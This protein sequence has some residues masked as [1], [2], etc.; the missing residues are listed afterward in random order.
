MLNPPPVSLNTHIIL[1]YAAKNY[2]YKVKNRPVDTKART[3]TTDQE[4]DNDYTCAI[5]NGL[6]RRRTAVFAMDAGQR[7]KPTGY[8]QK[9]VSDAYEEDGKPKQPKEDFIF[10]IG[11]VKVKVRHDR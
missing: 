8:K 3:S 2:A 5:R 6:T 11:Q 9:Y 10:R 7:N 4:K 1:L